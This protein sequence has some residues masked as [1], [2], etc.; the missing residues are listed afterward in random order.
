VAPD[1][2]LTLPQ[3]PPKGFVL[4]IHG[5]GW[6]LTGP[7]T[8]QSESPTVGWLIGHEWGVYNVDYRPGWLSVVDVVA[9]YDYLRRL[10][11]TAPMCALGQ[12]AGGQLAILLAASRRSLRCVISEAGVT[13][14]PLIPA[15]DPLHALM[16]HVFQGELWE[17]SPV[18]LASYIHG[19]L[20]C[21]GSSFDQVVPEP[22]QL[23][24]IKRAR[25]STITMLL[26]GAPTPG[27]PSLAHP[28]NFIHASITAAAQRL[29][30]SELT[31]VLASAVAG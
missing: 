20:L 12:S 14:L 27:G 13:D 26:A 8:L 16:E 9:A 29:F 24:A 30:T 21:A 4:V 2:T 23:A 15:S 19:T 18:R 25:S 3:G 31:K 17:F 7:T 5:G 6:V 11:P 22:D 1:N 28:P 10:D